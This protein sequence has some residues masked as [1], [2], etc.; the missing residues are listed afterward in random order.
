MGLMSS[1]T[2]KICE[3]VRKDFVEFLREGREL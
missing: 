2:Q 3:D 1:E